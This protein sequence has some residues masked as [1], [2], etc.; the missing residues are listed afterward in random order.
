M[1]GAPLLHV[2][3]TGQGPLAGGLAL[4][5]APW[6]ALQFP[7]ANADAITF[8]SSWVRGPGAADSTPKRLR[9]LKQPPY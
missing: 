8:N 1:G 4:L 5:C 9:L 7:T 6:A 3:C 2:T